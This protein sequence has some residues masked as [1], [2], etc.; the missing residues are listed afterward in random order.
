MFFQINI[1]QV[2]LSQ[3]NLNY[4]KD[5]LD[6]HKL[7]ILLKRLTLIIFSMAFM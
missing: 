5:I 4:A 1:N 6:E 3:I 2:Y 7:N